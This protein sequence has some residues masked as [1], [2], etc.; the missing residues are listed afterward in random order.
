MSYVYFSDHNAEYRGYTEQTKITHDGRINCV[1]LLEVVKNRLI[2][3]V[4]LAGGDHRSLNDARQA[5]CLARYYC[6]GREFVLLHTVTEYTQLS[7]VQSP[8]VLYR[9]RRIRRRPLRSTSDRYPSRPGRQVGRV[10][11]VGRV[12]R[13][14][15][16]VRPVPLVPSVLVVQVRR[17]C[18][19]RRAG[20]VVLA[21]LGLLVLP[22]LLVSM[23]RRLL[24]LLDRPVVQLVRLLRVVLVVPSVPVVLARH[25][26]PTCLLVRHLPGL[27]VLLAV[28][29]GRVVQPGMACTVAVSPARRRAV[30]VCRACRAYRVLQACRVCLACQAYRLVQV[31]RVGSSRC[32]VC[33]VPDS[34]RAYRSQGLPDDV[35]GCP[36]QWQSARPSNGSPP[37]RCLWRIPCRSSSH[38][39]SVVAH[40]VH[41]CRP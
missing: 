41:N 6:W 10:G 30:V 4:A 29:V 20:L 7:T 13:R 11:L 5:R 9:P 34:R 24:V 40:V 27:L 26:L 3:N 32:I 23:A 36:C 38:D 35:F 16:L 2:M 17:L 21:V 18:L 14:R 12:D 8:I 19:H 33:S 37:T 15:Q 39:A 28:L 22:A 25:R 1:R 31:D